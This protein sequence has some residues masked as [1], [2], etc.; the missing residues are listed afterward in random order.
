MANSNI[1]IPR[2]TVNCSNPECT[3]T[4][5]RLPAQLAKRN[6]HFCSPECKKKTIV[7]YKYDDVALAYVRDHLKEYG[8][9]A[10]ASHL[11]VTVHA[12]RKQLTEWR[13]K[14]V[15]VPYTKWVED[16]VIRIYNTKGISYR[17]RKEGKK[18]ITLERLTPKAPREPRKAKTNPN[19]LVPQGQVWRKPSKAA[20]Y[21]A[22]KKKA[23][24]KYRTKVV[25]PASVKMVRIDAKTQIE[26]SRSISDQEAIDNYWKK[27]KTA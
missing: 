25:D 14:G 19:K 11:K 21:P 18:W 3:S 7:S 12:L 23:A 22:P 9:E 17:Q 4:F 5:K 2:V 15:E 24:D 13:K 8:Y 27:R 20:A 6:R 16:G 10:V 1:R 26:V